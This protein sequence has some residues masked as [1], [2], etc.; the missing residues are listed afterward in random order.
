MAGSSPDEVEVILYVGADCHLCQI[1]RHLLMALRRSIPFRFREVEIASDPEL[2]R[3][4]L[5]E[6]PVVEVDG[7]VATQAPV[8]IEAVRAAVVRARLR[9]AALG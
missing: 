6:V 9:R 4:Y 3:R 8:E 2:E 1:A 5:L 7:E